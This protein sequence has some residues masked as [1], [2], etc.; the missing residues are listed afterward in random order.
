MGYISHEQMLALGRE[1]EK[2]DYGKYI[3]ALDK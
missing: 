2:T 3:L 1:M